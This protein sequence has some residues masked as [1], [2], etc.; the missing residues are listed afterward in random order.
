MAQPVTCCCAD[1]SPDCPVRAASLSLKMASSLKGVMDLSRT[2]GGTHCAAGFCVA[3]QL[4]HFASIQLK[5]LTSAETLARKAKGSEWQCQAS[6]S[7]PLAC[8]V[9]CRWFGRDT[10]IILT[11]GIA[12][13]GCLMRVYTLYYSWQVCYGFALGYLYIKRL[14]L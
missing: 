4:T 8:A 3:R 7:G 6:P 2:S 11:L 13:G 5:E 1:K 12:I 10:A 9:H 14:C